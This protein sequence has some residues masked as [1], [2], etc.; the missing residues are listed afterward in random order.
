MPMQ[1]VLFLCTGNSCRS[2]MAEALVNYFLSDSWEAFSAG[3]KPSG[4]VHP[5]AVQAMADLGID[6]S[7]HR[8]KPASEFRDVA[9]DRVI[10]VCDHAAQH[11]PAWLG[12]GTVQHIGFPDPAKAQGTDEQRLAV[13]R[14]VRDGI[15]KQ[16]LAY[17]QSDSPAAPTEFI[18]DAGER[19]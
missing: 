11:C 13:F 14:Q 10:T 18:L 7:T 17:L 5:M 2:Q 4:Y 16:V 9:F 12:K 15:R 1:K 8:S 6:L 19:P 3:T